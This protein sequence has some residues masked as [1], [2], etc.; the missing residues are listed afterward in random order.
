M[1]HS[2]KYFIP[3]LSGAVSPG[4]FDSTRGNP[5]EPSARIESCRNSSGKP[6]YMAC[7]QSGGTHEVCFGKARAIVQACVKSA[8]IAARPKAALFSA[9]KLS[10][11]ASRGAP[12]AADV[13]RDASA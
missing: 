3:F 7:K 12:S 1:R 11:P 8:M 4:F 9:E 5:L 10:A 6:A 13:A 2:V